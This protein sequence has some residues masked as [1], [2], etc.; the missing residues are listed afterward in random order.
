M[1][2]A[3]LAQPAKLVTPSGLTLPAEQACDMM[4]MSVYV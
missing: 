1:G 3:I 4:Q 2:R